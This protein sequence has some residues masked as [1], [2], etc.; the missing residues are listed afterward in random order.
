[1]SWGCHPDTLTT[2]MA[3]GQANRSG[4]EPYG[5]EWSKVYREAY[6]QAAGNSYPG[7]LATMLATI[8]ERIA[9]LAKEAELNG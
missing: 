9:E 7:S 3:C 5:L 2:A 6:K 4:H 8:D 1:M